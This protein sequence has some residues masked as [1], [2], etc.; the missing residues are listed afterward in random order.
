MV[1]YKLDYG[2][3]V[4]CVCTVRA[5][6]GVPRNFYVETL[7]AVEPVDPTAMGV[8]MLWNCS[9]SQLEHITRENLPEVLA[10]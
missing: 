5:C 2:I 10:L 6:T 3:P 9:D 8:P 4:R 7:Y 1:V